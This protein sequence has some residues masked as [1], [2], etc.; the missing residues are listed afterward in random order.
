MILKKTTLTLALMGTLFFALPMTHAFADEIKCEIKDTELSDIMKYMKS[1]LRAYNKGFDSENKEEM[2]QHANE[3]VMLSEKAGQL[4]PVVIAKES[5]DGTNK[6]EG[7]SAGQKVKY[8]LYQK[9]MKGLNAS[10]QALSK[11]TDNAE[12][13][14]LLA[15]VK[16]QNKQGHHAFRQKCK[17]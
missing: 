8:S 16:E 2:L 3:L 15:K 14:V 13:E 9:E 6:T 4:I 10:F 1:E 12:V 11:T 7:V 5:N 17:K